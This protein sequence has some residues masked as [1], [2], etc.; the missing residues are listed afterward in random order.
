M[1]RLRLRWILLLIIGSALAFIS[2]VYQRDMRAIDGRL[3]ADATTV[4]TAFGPV[5]YVEG[6]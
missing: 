4:E 6:G 3:W 1:R 2:W 5:S